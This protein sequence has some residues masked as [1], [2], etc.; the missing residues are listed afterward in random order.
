MRFKTDLESLVLGALSEGPL[1]GYG[2]VR[3]I[4]D[5]SGDLLRAGEGQ[6]YPALRS[7]EEAGLIVGEWEAQDGKPARRVYTLTEGGRGE[8]ATRTSQFEGFVK[9][10]QGV[11]SGSPKRAEDSGV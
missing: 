5:R 11:L 8:L 9:A 3:L 2:I 1:H 10:V 6:L 7:L 4:R